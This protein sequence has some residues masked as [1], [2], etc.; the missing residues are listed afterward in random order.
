MMRIFINEFCGHPF[1]MELSQEL[2]RRGHVVY[3][4][5]FADNT[6]TPK[7]SH[8]GGNQPV[9]LV[10]EGLH[11]RRAFNK[12][13]LFSRRAADIEYGEATASRVR[14]FRPDVVISADMPL[15]GQRVLL[16]ATQEVGARFVFWLQDIYC[17]AV[18]F[19]LGRKMPLLAPVGAWYY[20]QLEK[21]LLKKSDAIVCIAPAF[22]DHL[23]RWR[24]DRSKIAVIPNWGPVKEIVPTPKANP[25]AREN[26]V[27]DKF[28]FMY[29]G[30]LGMKHRPELLLELAKRLEAR[31]DAK[32]LVIAGGAGADWLAERANQVGSE[33]LEVLPLQPY[34][35]V[36]EAFG[37]A[38][39]LI[40][41][42]D[43]E[44]GSFA[45]PSKTLAYLCAGRPL[46][47]A[48]PDMN[49]AAR[50]VQQAD[51]GIVTSPDH[52]DELLEAAEL[53]LNNPQLCARLGGNAR[54]YAERT[55]SIDSV[56]DQFLGVFRG[57]SAS[58]SPADEQ[59][60][61]I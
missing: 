16:Q 9:G 42:L 33:V 11:I 17:T 49:E 61:T 32:L 2:A 10:I 41:L 8:S 37:A 45:V 34:K 19:V 46:I 27:A 1:G 36:Q 25:W 13:G 5:Y 3:Q 24:I 48:A 28:C 54:E 40:S 55:F 15:D 57:E 18:R 7:G 22:A 59:R 43:S 58:V 35:K 52:P 23:A 47:I 26:G 12:Y 14:E 39:V 51:A 56:A 29:S 60:V 30:T 53:L 20:E 6:S 38:D 50:V 21:S 4:T 44:A 31:K